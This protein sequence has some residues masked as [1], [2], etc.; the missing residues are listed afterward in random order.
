MLKFI[1]TGQSLHRIDSFS[2]VEK[3]INYLKAEFGFSSEWEGL[4]KKAICRSKVHEEEYDAHI[5]NNIC[6]IPW[7]VIEEDGSFEICVKGSGVDKTITTSVVTVDVGQTLVGGAESNPPSQTEL[8]WMRQSVEE[9]KSL[10]DDLEDEVQMK[11][12]AVTITEDFSEASHS[13]DE[14]MQHIQSDGH[15]YIDYFGA[16]HFPFVFYSDGKAYFSALLT[17]EGETMNIA[18]AI[19]EN[20]AI[21]PFE[22]QLVSTNSL[23]QFIPTALP[24]PCSLNINGTYYNGMDDVV[25]TI[26]RGE[27][28][29]DGITPHIGSNGNWYLG[30]KDTGVNAEGSDGKDGTNGKD[31]ADGLTPYIGDNGNW[32]IGN[33]DTGTKA[34]ASSSSGGH[35][36]A[37]LVDDIEITEE[38]LTE[39]SL[40]L[41]L[42]QC[43]EARL[44]CSVP[45]NGT[46]T[47]YSFFLVTGDG[48][49][50]NSLCS[51]TSLSASL[52][53]SYFSYKAITESLGEVTYG[54]GMSNADVTDFDKLGGMTNLIV[55]KAPRTIHPGLRAVSGNKNNFTFPVGTR[56]FTY[57]WKR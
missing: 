25:I 41:D 17:V 7:E 49:Y 35:S 5:L 39:I 16:G 36:F 54:S 19:D 37:E 40:E 10:V 50:Q 14:I 47:N 42:S 1:V 22:A 48:I 30:T 51:L 23:P 18:L 11:D 53:G 26:P 45:A 52:T 3:S 57:A 55:P 46:G 20:K 43:Y 44:F 21:T 38:G 33:T 24:N 28:G 12:L 13:S 15:A 2:P 8:E 56:I 32:F 31:G 27:D 4:D 9:M 6:L 34:A 29:A